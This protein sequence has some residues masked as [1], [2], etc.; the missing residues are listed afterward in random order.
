VTAAKAFS[1]HVRTSR[2]RQATNNQLVTY[3]SEEVVTVS[4]PDKVRIDRDGEH[5]DT[6]FYFDGSKATLFDPE[7]KLYVSQS[8][9]NTI[10]GMLQVLEKK[11]V[12]FPISDLLQSDP[13]DSLV[14]GLQSAYVIGRVNIHNKTFI[15]LVFTDASSDWQL[16]VEP[17]DKPL[18]R[19][20]QVIYK[21]EPGSPRVTMDLTDWNLNAQPEA[22]MFTFVKPTDAHE[23]QFFPSKAG[24]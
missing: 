6:E 2:D 15:H 10:D 12:S 20:M 18:A 22:A 16:W 24:K 9:P 5:Q 4:R 17:G 13:Y 7:S 21:L 11:R 19:A 14:K 1:V 3:F 8:A 23:I